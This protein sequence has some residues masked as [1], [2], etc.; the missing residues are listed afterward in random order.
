M[1]AMMRYPLQPPKYFSFHSKDLVIHRHLVSA[2]I[3]NDIQ[4]AKALTY[5]KQK[6]K[7]PQADNAVKDN[8]LPE[9][10]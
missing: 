8:C 1:V 6:R 4:S 9:N 7:Y 5:L 3:A 10:G 2:I